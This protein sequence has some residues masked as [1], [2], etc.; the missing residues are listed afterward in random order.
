MK[1]YDFMFGQ[2]TNTKLSEGQILDFFHESTLNIF[3]NIQIPFRCNDKVKILK[4]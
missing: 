2:F 1:H 3:S 4:S